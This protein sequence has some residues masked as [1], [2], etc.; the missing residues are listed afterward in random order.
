MRVLVIFTGKGLTKQ[1]YESLRPE[2]K[3]ET[4]HPAGIFLHACGFD[5]SGDLHVVDVW[6]S[7]EALN[8]FVTTRLMPAMQKLGFP[9]PEPAVIPLHNLNLFPAAQQFLVK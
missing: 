8:A 5:D 6:E 3:W 9:P 4:D 2:V 7:V 1:M